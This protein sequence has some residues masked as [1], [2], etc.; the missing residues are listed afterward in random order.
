VQKGTSSPS[1][2]LCSNI[3]QASFNQWASLPLPNGIPPST[4]LH[5]SLQ[6]YQIQL[7]PQGWLH[8]IPPHYTRSRCCFP[9]KPV[10]RPPL[11][12]MKAITTP[13]PILPTSQPHSCP[14]KS[15]LEAIQ[16]IPGG[17]SALQHILHEANSPCTSTKFVL[18]HPSMERP[19]RAMFLPKPYSL[20]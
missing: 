13:L 8:P 9:I 20:P 18:A 10:Q 16:P 11:P 19:P 4:V 6:F 5:Q 17:Q 3:Q 7:H 1:H 14:L 12:Q 15:A 2:W